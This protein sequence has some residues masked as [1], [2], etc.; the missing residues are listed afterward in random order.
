MPKGNAFVAVKKGRM[1][2]VG[3]EMDNELANE[4]DI[5]S[6]DNSDDSDFESVNEANTVI[7]STFDS[8]DE[9]KWNDSS[10]ND[11]DSDMP[12]I[13]PISKNQSELLSVLGTEKTRVSGRK[14]MSLNIS[15]TSM[16]NLDIKLRN[17]WDF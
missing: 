12:N 7:L 1:Q 3:D 17:T 10:D 15:M 2:N 16:F 14:L 6:S 9:Y 5:N 8:S 13:K 11:T 4:T